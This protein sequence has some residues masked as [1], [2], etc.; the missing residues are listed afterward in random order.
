MNEHEFTQ[1]LRRML[2]QKN[3]DALEIIYMETHKELSRRI[4]NE[5]I[6]RELEDMKRK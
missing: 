5:K 1:Q 4:M 3:T 2:A 6:K